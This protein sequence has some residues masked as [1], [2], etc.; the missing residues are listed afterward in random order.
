MVQ[1]ADEKRQIV[2][3]VQKNSKYRKD[4]QPFLLISTG[5]QETSVWLF[6]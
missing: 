5:F 4:F 3:R 1:E 6:L 2:W